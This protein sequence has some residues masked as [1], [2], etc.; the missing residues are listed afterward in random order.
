MQGLAGEGWVLGG[1]LAGGGEYWGGVLAG[2]G[3]TRE[4]VM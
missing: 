2:G 4:L 1:V 3:E